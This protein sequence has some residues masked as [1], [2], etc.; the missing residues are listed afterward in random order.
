MSL[1]I[2]DE[3][4]KAPLAIAWLERSAAAT[5]WARLEALATNRRSRQSH[6][7]SLETLPYLAKSPNTTESNTAGYR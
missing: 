4:S 2:A 5:G 1:V 7:S 3:F 6:R